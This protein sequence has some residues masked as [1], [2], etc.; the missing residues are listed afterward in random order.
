MHEHLGQDF[1]RS[2]LKIPVHEHC[3]PQAIDLINEWI[4]NAE[5]VILSLSLDI[6]RV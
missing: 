5:R 2:Y 6:L 4:E 3:P 1:I